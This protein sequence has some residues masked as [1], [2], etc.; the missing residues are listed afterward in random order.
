[1]IDKI[2][3]MNC[4]SRTKA[5]LKNYIYTYKSHIEIILCIYIILGYITMFG[6]VSACH[7]TVYQT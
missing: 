3:S 2:P 1:M 6:A 4:T 7:G 5:S